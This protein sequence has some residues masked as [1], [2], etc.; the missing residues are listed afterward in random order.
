ML[1]HTYKRINERLRDLVTPQMIRRAVH[2]ANIVGDG[3]YYIELKKFDDCLHID[4]AE[5]VN[6]DAVVAVVRNHLIVTI[7]LAKS[8][9]REYFSDGRYVIS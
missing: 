1:D 6:G 9:K 3:K 7:M 4:C 2:V 8:W 5:N